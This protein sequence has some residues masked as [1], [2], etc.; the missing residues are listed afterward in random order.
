MAT[1]DQAM[2]VEVGG[3]LKSISSEVE[4]VGKL[5]ER[6]E[7]IVCRLAS[8]ASLENAERSDLQSL[9]LIIQSLEAIRDFAAAAAE[10][11]DPQARVDIQPALDLV[12]LAAMRNRLAGVAVTGGKA[13]EAELF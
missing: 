3:V 11:A 7:R 10:T 12:R 6:F 9:D 8:E 1:P 13:G 5:V 4:Y 2:D